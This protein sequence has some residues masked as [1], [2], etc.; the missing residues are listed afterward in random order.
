MSLLQGWH[1]GE[2]AIQEKLGFSG[3][4]ATAYTWIE[5]EMPEQHRKFHTTRLPFIPVV[6][7]D[8]QHRPWTSIF[9]GSTGEPGFVSSPSYNRLNMKIKTWE[10]DP[11]VE[12]SQLFDGKKMLIAGIGIEFS[13]RRRNKFAGHIFELHQ[14][15]DIFHLKLLVNQAIGNCPKYINVRELDPH[16]TAPVIAYKR[17]YLEADERLPD[18]I[19]EF[20]RGS[21]TIF[22]GSSY[23]ARPEEEKRFPSHVGQNQRGGRKGMVRVRSDG[24]TLVIPDYS[25][26]RLL[27]SLGNIEATPVASV[28]IVDFETGDILYLTGGAHPA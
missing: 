8:D 2:R 27:T 4:M 18:E 15:G 9:A 23:E 28:T 1:R 16:P 19:V 22:I 17:P 10:G 20:V 26:N 25:G 6:T 3:I 21:D 14:N 7:L 12:N 24:R 13:T 5:G 11:F